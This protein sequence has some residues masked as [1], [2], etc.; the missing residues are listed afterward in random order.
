[1]SHSRTLSK[2]WIAEAEIGFIGGWEM[3]RKLDD[4][5]GTAE[6]N[7]AFGPPDSAVGNVT[8]IWWNWQTCYFEV[9]VPQGVEVQVLLCAPIF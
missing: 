9:V 5:G 8:R 3:W 4:G 2:A 6:N 1:M 7:F